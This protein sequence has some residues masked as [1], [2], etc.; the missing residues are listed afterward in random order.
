ME[1]LHL[2]NLTLRCARAHR[3]H[4]F[5]FLRSAFRP[6]LK[7]CGNNAQNITQHLPFLHS[8]TISEISWNVHRTHIFEVC[9]VKSKEVVKNVLVLAASY[10]LPSV[11][12]HKKKTRLCLVLHP[13]KGSVCLVLHPGKG[14]DT[15]SASRSG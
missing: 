11:R 1:T 13:G 9:D 10:R 8:L 2:N 14:N 15:A 7:A 6:K 5:T 4:C 3:A 12:L